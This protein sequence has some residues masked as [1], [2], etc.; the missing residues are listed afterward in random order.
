VSFV[1]RGVL[2]LKG[3]PAPLAVAEVAWE[4]EAS[5]EVRAVLADDSV[6]FREGVARLLE[7]YGVRVVAQ[8]GDLDGLMACVGKHRPELAVTDVRM[9][10][11][12]STEGVQAAERIRSEHPEMRVLLLSQHVE[13]TF[14][15]RL[16]AQGTA[17]FGYL[18]KERVTDVER[19]G[20]LA[21]RVAVGGI[22]IDAEVI[23]TLI[24]RQRSHGRLGLLEDGE[25]ALLR[26]LAQGDH[27]EELSGSLGIEPAAMP[28]AVGSMLRR[29]EVPEEDQAEPAI[30][31]L[32]VLARR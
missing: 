5:G 15:L 31:S 3:L 12:H 29:L 22:A 28:E 13:P 27:G 26:G 4:P 19:F 18:L 9:P 24:A 32:R 6:L 21:R 14:A 7:D 23:D 1:D 2:E 25:L 11:T 10:P 20:R 8:A 30:A 16:V 17:G